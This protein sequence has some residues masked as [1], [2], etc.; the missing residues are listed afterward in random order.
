MGQRWRR[1]SL[2]YLV[3]AVALALASGASAAVAPPIK[4]GTNFVGDPSTA[5]VTVDSAGTAYVAYVGP[6]TP[7]QLDFCKV[8]LAAVGCTVVSLPAPSAGASFFGPPSVIHIGTDVY[9]FESSAGGS[10][11]AEV[12]LDEWV[13]TNDGVSFAQLPYSV[14]FISGV[15]ASP[16]ENPV[17]ALPNGVIGV[18][19]NA[20]D[21]DPI[22]QTNTLL[23]PADYSEAAPVSPFATITAPANAYTLTN[24]SSEFASQLT[25]SL[26]VLGVFDAFPGNTA[27]NA[28]GPC[29]SSAPASLVF[30]YAPLTATATAS[31]IQSTLN[32][33]PGN[34]SAWSH[35]GEVDCDGDNPAVGGGPA[36]LGL[37]ETNETQL[38]DELVQ[39]RAFSPPS[40]FSAP[41]TIGRGSSADDSLSQ[42]GSGGIY[43]TWLD[44]DTGVNL[45]YSSNR[46]A[47]WNGPV[48]LATGDGA[49]LGS[50][51]SAVDAAGIGWVVYAE[52][53]AEYAQPFDKTYTF[54]APANTGKPTLSGTAAKGGTFD[55]STG[56]W[57][58]SPTLTYSW[59]RDGTLLAGVTGQT[60][61][62]GVLDEGSS[63]KCV[64]TASNLGG[65]ASATSN[66]KTIKTPY[67]KRCAPATGK[68]T[69]TQIGLLKLN[70]TRTQARFVYRRHS[71]RG[72]Q[73]KDFFCLTPEGVRAGYATPKLLRTLPKSER[74][75]YTSRV[76]WASTSDPYY[77][78]DGV[79]AGES[80]VTASKLL[81]TEAPF[82]IG[83]NNWYLARKAGYTAV[84]K[85]RGIV[86]EELGIADN[87][88][89]ETRAEESV[90][91]QSFY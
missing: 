15:N 37:L 4:I 62:V 41:V 56:T 88:L 35:L 9:L 55:C 20:P 85:V 6:T 44:A 89:T 72:F 83:K 76:V 21:T 57:T 30:A 17:I 87:S 26:G 13:S 91:M 86:V 58:G 40:T 78:L 69:G 66:S 82:H 11:D 77:E 81:H 23:S 33:S 73:Y 46:G 19:D 38:T 49:D 50:L 16:D 25:G 52:N 51:V 90:L 28:S 29:P 39:Y 65:A 54:L 75:R 47:S 10:S 5:A 68:M 71:T 36:G 1:L 31:Q 32:T 67:V 14:S 79:R 12:G 42:D 59:Y 43:A 80:I 3:T 61:S 48:A 22:F 8:A 34:G 27:P 70:M 2:V 63:F 24:Q 7:A 64:V 45:A 18:G 60:Y 84:L 53:G 74:K